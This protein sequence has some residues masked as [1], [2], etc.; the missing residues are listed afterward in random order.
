MVD[1]YGGVLKGVPTRLCILVIGLR[2]HSLGAVPQPRLLF[3]LGSSLQAFLGE[4]Q[5]CV[6]SPSSTQDSSDQEGQLFL[7]ALELGGFSREA[8]IACC[9]GAMRRTG[10]NYRLHMGDTTAPSELCR[11]TDTNVLLAIVTKWEVMGCTPG[12]T[13]GYSLLPRTHK[14]QKPSIR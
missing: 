6:C 10:N 14:M 13:P 7:L 9:Y 3:S 2:G 1:S 12:T 4:V 11:S 5:T 8:A